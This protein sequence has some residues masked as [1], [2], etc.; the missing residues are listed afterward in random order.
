MSKKLFFNLILILLIS[1]TVLGTA[2]GMDYKTQI[3][4]ESHNG[5]I[6]YLSSYSTGK[7]DP[8]DPSG[9]VAE[10][11]AF[12]AD[13]NYIYIVSGETQ[14]LTIVK[15]KSDGTCELFKDLKISEILAKENIFADDLTSVSY[16]PI[17]KKVAIAV[18]HEDYKEDGFIVILDSD[19]NYEKYYNA[20]CQPDMVTFSPDGKYIFT[21]NEGEPRAGYEKLD[22]AGSEFEDPVDPKGSVT[23]VKL[24]TNEAK[25]IDFSTITR[26]YA[27]ENKVLLKTGSEPVYDLEPEFVAVSE[28]SKTAYV[29]IQENNAIG[30]LDIEACFDDISGNEWIYVKGLGFKDHSLERNAIDLTR[31]DDDNDGVNEF[32]EYDMINIKPEENVFGVYMPD[33]ISVVTIGNKEYVLTANEG[34]ARE[35]GGKKYGTKEYE[36]VDSERINKDGKIGKKTEYLLN[37]E[38]DGLPHIEIKEGEDEPYYLLGG[39]SFSIW[40]AEDLSLV[41]DSGSEF[42]KITSVV[43]PEFFN[44]DHDELASDKRS[45]KKGPEPESVEILKDGEKVYAVIGI[46]RIGGFFLYDITT[47]KEA[48]YVDYLNVRMFNDSV[49]IDEQGDLGAEGVCTVTADKSPTGKPLIIVGNEVSGSVTVAQ[50]NTNV[51]PKDTLTVVFMEENNKVSDRKHLK[52]GDT[53]NFSHKTPYKSGFMFKGW[54]LNNEIVEE[55]EVTDNTVI[56]AEFEKLPILIEKEG[57]NKADITD[58]IEFLQYSGKIGQLANVPQT[59]MIE[60]GFDFN[61]DNVIDIVD[62]ILYLKSI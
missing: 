40:D 61:G 25:N 10:I 62:V 37:S 30:A 21:A 24:E 42:E 8:E 47:P 22:D 59:E 2:A 54:N 28:D 55:I 51:K 1:C 41:F 7:I 48:K 39:R 46:E 19:G 45:S 17:S 53:L 38:I 33:G 49:G 36:N 32:E 6:E 9:G 3:N 34:D 4:T 26:E 57:K 20:G 44:T 35:W 23:V 5:I 52:K 16:C 27:I 13:K 11:V 60:K 15:L 56:Y 12:N 29:S 43:F 58:V 18:Q 50:L 14:E 31:L